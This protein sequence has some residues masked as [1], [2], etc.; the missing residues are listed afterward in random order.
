MSIHTA[1][2]LELPALL[3]TPDKPSDKVAVF[4][5]GMGS[6]GV[7]YDHDHILALA[8]S[9]TSRGI[10]FL[11]LNNRGA[12]KSQTIHLIDQQ[13]EEL[14]KRFQGGCYF[15]KI[16]QCILDIDAAANFL[17][18]QGYKNL[19]LIG[20]STG[21]NKICVYHARAANN[22]Y[23]AYVLAGPGDDSGLFYS[24]LGPELFDT[25]LRYAASAVANDHGLKIMPK[26]TGMHPFSAQSTLDILGPDEPYNTFPY[27]EATTKRL[28]TKPLF[29]DYKTINLP[30]AVIYGE[31]DEYTYTAGG[32]QQALDI[33]RAE[34]N[35]ELPASLFQIIPD[36][37]HSFDGN[38]R[39]YSQ[40][41]SDWL[42]SQL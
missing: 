6:T 33:L 32:T 5:H 9:L 31:H 8:E 21:A 34:M 16:E 27:F 17:V 41:V 26:Y 7:F 22:P 4:L 2:F 23:S 30:L 10:S 36:A 39:E 40:V 20:E 19:A 35:Q 13:S 28:G 38:D 42:A 12:H 14:G 3:F 11:A 25:A 1:D 24:E 18:Q 37:S 15:E 29:G